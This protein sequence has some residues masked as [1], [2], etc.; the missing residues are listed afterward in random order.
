MDAENGGFKCVHFSVEKLPS[1]MIEYFIV[2]DRSEIF[3]SIWDDFC[4]KID[5]ASIITFDDIHEHVWK[6]TIAKCKELLH[7]LVNKSFTYSDIDIKCFGE[8][9]KIN[10]YVTNLYHAIRWCYPVLVSSLPDPKQWIPEAAKNITM[11]LDF[12]R[13][14][15]QANNSTVQTHAVHLCLQMKDL[16]RLKGDFSVVNNLNTQVCICYIYIRM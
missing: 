12:A 6:H 11:Y 5:K 7:K 15:V 3:I 8:A 2:F 10:S 1:D 9:K 16:L 4:E 13:D 14:S